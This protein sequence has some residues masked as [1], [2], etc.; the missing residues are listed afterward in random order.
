MTR[1]C[2]VLL[3][4]FLVGCE[5]TTDR[6]SRE[7]STVVTRSQGP[8]DPSCEKTPVVRELPAGDWDG[9]ASAKA[10]NGVLDDYSS[11]R[12]DYEKCR[13]WARGQR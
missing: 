6:A 12:R 5:T 7:W 4:L 8:V 11:L 10:V 9:L 1:A 13:T 3:S 2:I